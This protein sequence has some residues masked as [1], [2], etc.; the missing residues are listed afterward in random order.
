MDSGFA[1][2]FMQEPGSQTAVI[3]G[4]SLPSGYDP[5]Q[6]FEQASLYEFVSGSNVQGLPIPQYSG[7]VLSN[8]GISAMDNRPSGFS[9]AP[10]ATGGTFANMSTN[11]SNSFDTF[12][13][14][15]TMSNVFANLPRQWPAAAQHP[16]NPPMVGS[17]PRSSY[18][19]NADTHTSPPVQATQLLTAPSRFTAIQE[20]PHSRP[21]PNPFAVA[22]SALGPV[23]NSGASFR[24][25]RN[26]PAFPQSGSSAGS[27]HHRRNQRTATLTPTP[28]IPA[29][30]RARYSQ[31]SR[32]RARPTSTA[33]TTTYISIPPTQQQTT[34]SQ[35]NQPAAS[36]TIGPSTRPTGRLEHPSMQ[37]QASSRSP[38][39]DPYLDELL[40]DVPSQYRAIYRNSLAGASALNKTKRRLDT[41]KEVRP[42]P[43]E[44]E[45]MTV[46]MEC[47]ICMGQ[48][49]DTVLLPCG[50]AILCRWCADEL[51][52]SSKG[53]LRERA[54]CPMCREPVK[55]KHRIY[56]P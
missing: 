14:T 12:S 16:T 23:S 26:A 2:S 37:H 22:F 32:V 24:A 20:E 27:S 42:E 13:S 38:N 46:N 50:H 25:S 11:T 35:S 31:S 8:D 49:V 56:F 19:P 6:S 9:I 54:S 51:M 39:V 29:H 43:K 1:S 7:P 47:K 52:P 30:N 45:E 36:T 3:P 15:Q 40:R 48:V 41:P 17:V 5:T 18:F 55:Q 53:Y 10:P 33:S 4:M 44:T 21:P 34:Q 28:V